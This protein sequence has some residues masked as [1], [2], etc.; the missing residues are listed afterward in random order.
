MSLI[1]IKAHLDKLTPHELRH[2]ALKSWT[3]FLEKEGGS[4]VML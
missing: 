3:A 2:L 4:K 1:E